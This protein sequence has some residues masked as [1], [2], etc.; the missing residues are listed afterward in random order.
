M[1]H[2]VPSSVNIIMIPPSPLRFSMSPFPTDFSHQ[3]R[4]SNPAFPSSAFL[5]LLHRAFSLCPPGGATHPVLRGEERRLQGFRSPRTPPNGVFIP[6]RPSLGVKMG[7]S[8][9][10]CHRLLTS[11]VSCS[12]PPA[13]PWAPAVRQRL[14]FTLIRI[15]HLPR[16]ISLISLP[17]GN[18]LF[19]WPSCFPFPRMVPPQPLSSSPSPVR[20]LKSGCF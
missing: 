2:L 9:S 10:L 5:R 15:A 19:P 16:L 1:L 4:H 14:L 8:A 17:P 12:Y 6:P 7:S 11:A 3:P 20:S 13:S 18:T